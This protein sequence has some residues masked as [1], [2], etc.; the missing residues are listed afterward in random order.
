MS[1]VVNEDEVFKLLD[2]KTL[3]GH[4][5]WVNTVST[6]TDKKTQKNYV[7]SGSR[8]KTVK[9]WDALGGTLVKTLS[10]H[11]CTVMSVSTFTDEKTKKVY[12]VSGGSD[13][14]VKVWDALGGTLVKTLSDH[15]GFVLSVSTFTNEKKRREEKEALYQKLIPYMCKNVINTYVLPYTVNPPTT[16][17]VSCTSEKSIKIW[18]INTV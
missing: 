16:T 4:T 9:V 7:V 1:D 14:T 6:F 8:D 5:D 15:N 18:N 3:S 2:V 10:G 13:Y 12:V 17:I 11:I